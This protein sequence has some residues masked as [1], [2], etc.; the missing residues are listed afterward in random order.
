MKIEE[1]FVLISNFQTTLF[2]LQRFLSYMQKCKENK[3]V[4]KNKNVKTNMEN[5][6]DKNSVGMFRAQLLKIP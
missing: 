2:Y 6:S 4:K 3:K 5:K 1:N